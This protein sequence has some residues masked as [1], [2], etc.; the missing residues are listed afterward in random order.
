MASRRRRRHK[1]SDTTEQF[2]EKL[3]HNMGANRDQ[4]RAAKERRREKEKIRE[5][6]KKEKEDQKL[7]E[8]ERRK[9]EEIRR[10]EELERKLAEESRQIENYSAYKQL[11]LNEFERRGVPL[12][13]ELL[14]SVREEDNHKHFWEYHKCEK[15]Y[16][17][18]YYNKYLNE[19]IF[20]R[21][22]KNEASIMILEN[23]M[24]RFLTMDKMKEHR[25][26]DKYR[27]VLLKLNAIQSI[28]LQDYL[29]Q[30]F[31]KEYINNI[32]ELEKRNQ[33][34]QQ[35]RRNL[36]QLLQ[37]IIS[38]ELM[39]IDDLEAFEIY[40]HSIND[41]SLIVAELLNSK[42]YTDSIR[43]AEERKSQILENYETLTSR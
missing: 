14:D 43:R 2:F 8:A 42:I 26:T 27:S 1:S 18:E 5:Q 16:R 31:F 22:L 38:N 20:H 12:I 33:K 21:D 7:R 30:A 25:N 39:L 37:N 28:K 34:I 6:K 13:A 36:E 11:I 35:E 3:F 29:D 41:E 9:E 24:K 32:E 19:N 17:L 10:K 4:L 23:G 40:S 15:E